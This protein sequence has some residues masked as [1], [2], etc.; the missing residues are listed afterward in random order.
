MAKVMASRGGNGIA[1]RS[2]TVQLGTGAF[3]DA[4]SMEDAPFPICERHLIQIA[5]FA[6]S[7]GKDVL[8]G[9]ADTVESMW[10]RHVK[11][12]KQAQSVVYYLDI[13]DGYVKIGYTTNLRKRMQSMYLT[14]DKLMAVELGGAAKE[15]E[16]HVQFAHLREGRSERFRLDDD[17][18]AHIADRR[19]RRPH[20]YRV[21]TIMQDEIGTPEHRARFDSTFPFPV[22]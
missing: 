16:R 5:R 18:R 2:C 13:G 15:H 21:T 11:R 14:P 9:K 22:A 8:A 17:L 20:H 7:L 1:D 10:Q 4:P 19:K 12:R 6:L 3:C